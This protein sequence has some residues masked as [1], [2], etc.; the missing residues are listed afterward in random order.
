MTLLLAW[1][2]REDNP[3]GLHLASDSLLSA[4]KES[5]QYAPKITRVHTLHEYIGYC[6]SSLPGMACILQSNAV[7]AASNVLSQGGSAKSPTLD[8]RAKAL[9]LLLDD[10][11]PTF[12]PSWLASGATL[13]YCGFDVRKA[14]FRL[15]EISL[16]LSGVSI[17]ERELGQQTVL[18][19][20]SGQAKARSILATLKLKNA[21]KTDDILHVL[22]AVIEDPKVPSVGGAPQMVTIGKRRS[23]MVGFNWEVGGSTKSTLLGIPLRFRSNMGKIRFLDQDLQH[24]QYLR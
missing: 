24:A 12:P 3:T 7:L 8:A 21:L 17:E 4:G 20:G 22:K 2:N 9:V 16:A 15:F 10:I 19:Y 5:W 23:Q 14:K 1:L 11:I 13:L 6:G 18:C